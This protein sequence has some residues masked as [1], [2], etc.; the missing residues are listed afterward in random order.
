MDDFLDVSDVK[1]FAGSIFWNA[2]QP[3]IYEN[4]D[5]N[6]ML[7]SSLPADAKAKFK[8]DGIRPTW[9]ITTNKAIKSPKNL[10]LYRLLGFTQ[11]H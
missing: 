9:N 1:Y 4:S 3:G 5:I 11:N 10:F 7:K 6:L 2:S 8:F